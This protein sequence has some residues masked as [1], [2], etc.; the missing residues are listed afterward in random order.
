MLC[1][2]AVLGMIRVSAQRVG[3]TMGASVKN[4]RDENAL[5]GPV[6]GYE[7]KQDTCMRANR[8]FSE[9]SVLSLQDRRWVG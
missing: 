3:R 7:K 2:T 4:A 8:V 1:E 6:L 5:N 9:V